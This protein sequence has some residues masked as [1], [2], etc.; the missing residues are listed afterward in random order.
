M[1][2][3]Q[4]DSFVAI[5]AQFKT[6]EKDLKES[7]AND[8]AGLKTDLTAKINKALT[9]QANGMKFIY[10]KVAAIEDGIDGDDG[11]DGLTPTK[12]ELLALIK[13]LIPAATEAPDIDSIVAQVLEKIPKQGASRV[14]WGAHPLVIAQ[15]GTIKEKVARHI[16][17]KGT[18]VTSVVRNA[19]GVVDVTLTGGGGG[20]LTELTATETPNGNLTVFTFAAAAAQ[21]TY[22]VVDNVWMKAVSK[23]GTTNWTWNGGTLKA[24]LAIPPTDEIFAF[25]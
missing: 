9:E 15:T 13:P 14:G 20:G 19:N 5:T 7:V 23:A 22:I 8:F 4:D 25:V 18:A 3:R 16:N 12:D 1:I 21:P 24:T 10:D 11:T 2:K 17:F 6:L